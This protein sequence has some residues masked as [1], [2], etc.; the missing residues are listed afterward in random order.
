[1]D[2]KVLNTIAPMV[3]KLQA[4]HRYDVIGIEN[5]PQ[6]GPAL[7]V[8]THSLATYDIVLLAGKISDISKSMD[9]VLMSVRR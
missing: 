3:Y 5:I 8:C 4:Y 2:E 7:I 9:L 6:E 1:M